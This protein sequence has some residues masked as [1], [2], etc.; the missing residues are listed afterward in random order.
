MSD[1]TVTIK[2]PGR[3]T[4]VELPNGATN[5]DLLSKIPNAK[6]LDVRVKG[7]SISSKPDAPVENGVTATATPKQVK[8]GS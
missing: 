2:Q 3:E 7:E 5:A 8:Q 4:K 6:N 1:V